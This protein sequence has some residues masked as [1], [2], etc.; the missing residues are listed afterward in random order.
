M[1][2]FLINKLFTP[3]SSLLT[4]LCTAVPLQ[5]CCSGFSALLQGR[6]SLIAGLLQQSEYVS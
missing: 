2:T 6:D 1:Y 4:S 3:H 5:Y